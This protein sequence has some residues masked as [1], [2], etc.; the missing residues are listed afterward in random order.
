MPLSDFWTGLKLEFP[1]VAEKAVRVLLPFVSTYRCEAGFSAYTYTKNKYRNRLNASSDL[2][3]QLS[4]LK[5][6]FEKLIA[7]TCKQFYFPH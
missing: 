1:G 3:V 4:D 2:R 7:K 5:V 6:N